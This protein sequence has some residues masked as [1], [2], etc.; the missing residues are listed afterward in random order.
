MMRMVDGEKR[1][2]LR[3]GLGGGGEGRRGGRWGSGGFGNREGGSGSL[4]G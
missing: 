3:I 2:V 4:G 1:G